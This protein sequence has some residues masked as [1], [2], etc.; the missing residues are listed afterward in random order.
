MYKGQNEVK[1]ELDDLLAVLTVKGNISVKII[2]LAYS[3]QTM[4]H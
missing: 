1:G 3:L 4:H 2:L